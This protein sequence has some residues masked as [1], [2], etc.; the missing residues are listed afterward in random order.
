VNTTARP[1]VA[2]L[3]LELWAFH[4]QRQ[5]HVLL[6]GQHVQTFLVNPQA[7][8]F[9]IAPLSL[10]PGGHEIGFLAAEPPTVVADATPS[11]DHRALSFAVGRWRWSSRGESR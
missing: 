11:A 9:R 3:D 5:L 4:H 8:V 2:A 10:T 6:D 7:R 1:I